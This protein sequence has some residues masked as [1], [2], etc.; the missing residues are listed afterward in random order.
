MAKK[1]SIVLGIN[2][3]EQNIVNYLQGKLLRVDMICVNSDEQILKLS[4]TQTLL[5]KKSE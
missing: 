5:L 3:G 4:K 2:G 1:N